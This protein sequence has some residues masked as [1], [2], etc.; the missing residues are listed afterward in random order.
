MAQA[1]E[2]RTMSTPSLH[3]FVK[4]TTAKNRI[5]FGDVRRLQRN[6]LPDG[7]FDREQAELLLSL[8][9]DVARADGAWVKWLVT[10]IVDFAVWGERPTGTVEGEPADWLRG[11]L[12]REGAPKAGRRIAREIQR[13]AMRVD[14]SIAA[15]AP[16]E[17]A[18]GSDVAEIRIAA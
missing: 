12:T 2:Y 6:I 7:V 10:S 14:D 4:K 1:G 11:V 3:D 15:L 8:D 9:R 13:E 18:Q 17:V 16:D 5:T